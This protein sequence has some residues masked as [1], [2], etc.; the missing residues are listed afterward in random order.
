[1]MKTIVL[2]AFILLQLQFQVHCK[3]PPKLGKYKLW[4]KKIIFG[5]VKIWGNSPGGI[6]REQLFGRFTGGNLPGENSLGGILL[7]L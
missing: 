1:M 7:V 4:L 6:F 2:V 5:V 3:A